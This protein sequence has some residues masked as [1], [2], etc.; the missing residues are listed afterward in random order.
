MGMMGGRKKE[1]KGDTKRD[2]ERERESEKGRAA[3]QPFRLH[4]IDSN[5]E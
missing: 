2:G 1:R 3:R 4:A 5:R